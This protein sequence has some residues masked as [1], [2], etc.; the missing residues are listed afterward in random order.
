MHRRFS[1][2]FRWPF[3]ILLALLIARLAA[4]AICADGSY[5]WIPSSAG[6]CS[7][8]GGVREWLR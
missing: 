6:T 4:T 5:S 8:R 3:I 1:A 2:W 7:S